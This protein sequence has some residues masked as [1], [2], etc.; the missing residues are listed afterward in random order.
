MSCGTGYVNEGAMGGMRTIQ[1]EAGPSGTSGTSGTSE[2]PK[3]S[4]SKDVEP[5]SSL[6]YMPE[7]PRSRKRREMYE[8][9][10]AINNT[11]RP[12]PAEITQAAQSVQP[13]STAEEHDL[14]L[15]ALAGPST[16]TTRP[17]RSDISSS[18]DRVSSSLALTLDRL[19]ESL[20]SHT[21]GRGEAGEARYFV[22]VKL[23]TEAMR[24]VLEVL[25]RVR[26]VQ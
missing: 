6:T 17:Q 2:A 4:A 26:R 16:S 11:L 23:H 7:S 14:D 24:D 20:A 25:E 13:T 15:S 12:A 18:L 3:V 10:E 9:G 1:P 21:T 19:S 22:D 5:R 8:T